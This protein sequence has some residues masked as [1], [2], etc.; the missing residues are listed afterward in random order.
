MSQDVPLFLRLKGV[1]MLSLASGLLLAAC[2][3]A[4]RSPSASATQAGGQSPLPPVVAVVDG[5]EIPT[6]IFEMY[7]KNGREELGLSDATEEGRRKIELLREGVVSDLIDRALIV[8]EAERRGLRVSA[9]RMAE[10]ERAAVARLG[11]EEKFKDYLAE[12]R[13]TREEYM[14]QVVRGE[15]YAELMRAELSKDVSIKEEE[16]K[17]YYARHRRDPDF[18]LPERVRA[19]HILVAA[20]PQ[21]VAQQLSRERRLAGDALES[22]VREEMARRR[23]RAEDLR[24]QGVAAG[25]GFAALARAHSDDEGTRGRGGDRGLFAR[26]SHAR[27]PDGGAFSLKPGRTSRVVQTEYGFHVVRVSVHEMA[28]PQTLDE[29]TPEIRRRLFAPREAEL[30]SDWLQ[31]A[32]RQ[33]KV[34]INE[35]FRIGKL[36]DR[37]PST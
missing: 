24:R 4:S 30:L 26:D 19:S 2:A 9:E 21:Q 5:R 3:C 23:A 34:H 17:A 16:I 29:A 13:L 27:A 14:T 32:R 12:H 33:A 8:G 6:K 11:G 20:R 28:R 37:F 7:L 18:Q 10:A 31:Q 35:P 25:A 1:V 36:R 15:L 22:A